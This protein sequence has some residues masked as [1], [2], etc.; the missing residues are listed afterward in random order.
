MEGAPAG[1]VTACG[2]SGHSCQAAR[3][4]AANL[5]SPDGS[6]TI[7]PDS[8][9]CDG[10]PFNPEPARAMEQYELVLKIMQ[11][12]ALVMERSHGVCKSMDGEALRQH[13]LGQL[14]GQFEGKATGETFNMSGKT[15]SFC[16]RVS[17]MSLLLNASSEKA[18]RLR[19][20]NRITV[21]AMQLGVTA[22]TPSLSSIAELEPQACFAK[23]RANA[24]ASVFDFNCIE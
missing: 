24:R 21:G 19:R 23:S 17:V 14:N 13:F 22:R 9:Y 5:F 4:C 6:K 8:S 12:M 15:T 10:A 16:A 7:Y 1:A 11:D 18:R 2:E 20:G 3:Q